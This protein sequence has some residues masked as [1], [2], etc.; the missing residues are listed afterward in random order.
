MSLKQTSVISDVGCVGEMFQ[1]QKDHSL[2][3][4][5]KKNTVMDTV[6]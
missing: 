4:K 6:R 5:T 1:T 2:S 3:E